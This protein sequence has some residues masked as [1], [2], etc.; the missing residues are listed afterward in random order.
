MT[1]T[2]ADGDR[3]D[4]HNRYTLRFGQDPP[5]DAFWSLTMYDLPDFYLSTTRSTGTPSATAPPACAATATD[6]SPS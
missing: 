1:Y 2:D 6:R 5:V 4:G 3:L